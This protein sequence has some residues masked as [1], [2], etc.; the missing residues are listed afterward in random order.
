MWQRYFVGVRAASAEC[1]SGVAAPVQAFDIDLVDLAVNRN[2]EF[3]CQLLTVDASKARAMPEWSRGLVAPRMICNQ[4]NLPN[5]RF[6]AEI[7]GD[8]GA[9]GQ[10]TILGRN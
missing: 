5:V 3:Q 10:I 7:G 6:H 4:T 8:G 2:F 9:D 1:S